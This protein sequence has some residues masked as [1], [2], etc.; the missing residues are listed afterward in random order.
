MT[1]FLSV[2]RNMVRR[3]VEAGNSVEQITSLLNGPD[4]AMVRRWAEEAIQ[5]Q[6]A[7]PAAREVTR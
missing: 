6:K 7:A 5:A 4:P 2:S 1:S 3:M